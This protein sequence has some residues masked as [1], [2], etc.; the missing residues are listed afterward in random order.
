MPASYEAGF[1]YAAKSRYCNQTRCYMKQYT[2]KLYMRR[3]CNLIAV[4]F[5]TF[6]ILTSAPIAS[7]ASNV[8][9]TSTMPPDEMLDLFYPVGSYFETTDTTFNP[10]TAWGGTWV[11]D[12][13]GNIH[14]AS[15]TANGIT[16]ITGATGGNKDAIVV[17]HS[18]TVNSHTHSIPALSGTAA[19]AGAHTHAPSAPSNSDAGFC[20]MRQISGRSGT[21]NVA[22]GSGRYGFASNSGWADVQTKRTTSSAGAHTHSVTTSAS[23]TGGSSPGTNSVGSSGTNANMQPYKVVKRWHRTA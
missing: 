11:E 19:S 22:T 3:A 18:H 12:D 14:I 10:N 20:A 8:V 2:N 16:Y 15:G 21:Y 9:I 7:A 17:S 1:F 5:V 4:V 13:A 6:I 23:T